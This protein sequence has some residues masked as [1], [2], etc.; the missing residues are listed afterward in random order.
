MHSFRKLILVDMKTKDFSKVFTSLM[1]SLMKTVCCL[2]LH[3]RSCKLEAVSYIGFY[4][5]FL[6]KILVNII[7]ANLKKSNLIV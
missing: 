2:L 6:H 3:E 5:I 4:Y 1:K 7:N